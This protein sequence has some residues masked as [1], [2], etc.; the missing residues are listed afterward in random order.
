VLTELKKLGIDGT[1]RY[2]VKAIPVYLAPEDARELLASAIRHLSQDIEALKE[3]IAEAEKEQSK[4]ALR[5]LEK[6]KSYREALLAAFKNY[7]AQL[8]G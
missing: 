5:R 7:L 6:E 3:K 1:A 8:E 2:A 4:T